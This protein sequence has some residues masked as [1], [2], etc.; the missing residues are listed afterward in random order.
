MIIPVF[1]F[2]SPED[3]GKIIGFSAVI[4]EIKTTARGNRAVVLYNLLIQDQLI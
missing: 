1:R 2:V 4:F 3:P